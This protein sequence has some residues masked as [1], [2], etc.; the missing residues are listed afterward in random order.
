MGMRVTIGYGRERRDYEV[1]ED[2]LIGDRRTPASDLLDRQ[3]AVRAALEAPFHFPALRRAVTPDD[4]VAVIVDETLSHLPDALI[5][6]LEHLAQAGVAPG[7]ITLLSAP[8]TSGQPWIDDLPE[9]FEEV[10]V[11][12]HDP[13]DRKRL[14]YLATSRHG[15]RLYLNRTVVDADQLVVVSARRYDALLGQS[16]AEGAIYPAL[17]DTATIDAFQGRVTLAEPGA[18]PTVTRREAVETAWLL[19]APFFVQVIEGAAAGWSQVVAGAAEASIEAGRHLDGR[20]RVPLSRRPYLV[21]ATLTGDS[22]R[23]SFADWAVALACAARVVEPNGRIVLLA[24]GGPALC[25]DSGPTAELLRNADEPEQVLKHL[26]RQQTLEML[27][28]LQWATAATR[29]RL[30]ILS[31][32]PDDTVEELFATPLQHAGQV[33]RL[34][35]DS[36]SY[37]FLEDAHRTLA[38]LEEQAALEPLAAKRDG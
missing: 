37:L 18:E 26:R 3:A 2:R 10:H 36:G 6:V 13:A 25:L 11:E 32:L 17:S 27:P 8:T 20:W 28:A 4:H 33:Q 1:A 22:A 35:D 7:N 19:G 34:L 14:S 12:V 29:A 9:A 30:Y 24:D 38:V 15:H 23:H 5:P 21:V 16:G 31:G